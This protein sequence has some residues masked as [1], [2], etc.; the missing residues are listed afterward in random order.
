MR[1][2]RNIKDG[3]IYEWHPILA[4]NP[5]CEEVTEEQAFPE[6]FVKPE[7]VSR[8]RKVQARKG[9]LNLATTDIPEDRPYTSPELEAEASRGMPA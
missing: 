2:L 8:V 4:E 7:V 9:A 3:T 6:R 5:S 1:Y